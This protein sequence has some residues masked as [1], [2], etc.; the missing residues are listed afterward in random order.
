[1]T[2][3]RVTGIVGVWAIRA[4]WGIGM[5]L[6]SLQ[7]IGYSTESSLFSQSRDVASLKSSMYILIAVNVLSLLAAGLTMRY[8][9]IGLVLGGLITILDLLG[10]VWFFSTGII[11]T[12]CNSA[13]LILDILILYY[14][15]KY[16]THEPEKLAFR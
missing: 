8:R 1:M 9:R 3:P 7:Q 12:V 6:V 2:K 14:L 15:Y 5:A 16:L 10:L 4:V 13:F 11:N